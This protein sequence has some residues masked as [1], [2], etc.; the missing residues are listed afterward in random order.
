MLGSVILPSRM[1]PIGTNV[2]RSSFVG[3]AYLVLNDAGALCI[4]EASIF[5]IFAISSVCRMEATKSP[6][7]KL[8]CGAPFMAS[9]T[10]VLYFTGVPAK[11][12]NEVKGMVG[13]SGIGLVASVP[14]FFIQLS[15]RR[16]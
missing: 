3:G 10:A 16:N 8:R 15:T 11:V 2:R 1:T 12:R 7:D 14:G 13:D 6:P 4:R 9:D 5:A